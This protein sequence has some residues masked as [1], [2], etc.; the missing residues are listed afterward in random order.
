MTEILPSFGL[1]ILKMPCCKEVEI[2]GVSFKCDSKFS[3][4]VKNKLV[5]D[6]KFLYISLEHCAK[7]VTRPSQ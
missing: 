4:H 1:Q 6:N 2:W 3:V 5:K 7:R